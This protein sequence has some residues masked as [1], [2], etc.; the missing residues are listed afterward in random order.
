MKQTGRKIVDEVINWAVPAACAAAL[1]AWE[2]VPQEWRHYWPVLCVAM[3]GIF[4]LA[5]EGQ[6]RREVK[7]LRKIHEEADK[8][9]EANG[10]RDS[11]IASAFKAMLDDD[12]GKLYV[13][14]LAQGYTTE[15]ERR[16]YRRL[17]AAYKDMGGNGE[18]TERKERFFG[19]M[20]EEEWKLK[21]ERMDGE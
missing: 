5:M 15:D 1:L 21:N 13:H 10:K 3:I 6:T 16:R 12:M 14:C 18:A 19:I 9:A 7:R 2:T 20:H 17:D 8:R 4:S 11:D